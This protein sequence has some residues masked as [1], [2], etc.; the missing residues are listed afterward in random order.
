MD[1]KVIFPCNMHSKPENCHHIRDAAKNAA[2]DAVKKV[3]EILGVDVSVPKEVE[4]FRGNLR[5]GAS[6]RR[7][8]DKG[9]LAIIGAVAIAA[10]AALWA[11]TISMITRGN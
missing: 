11:G 6:L 8:A 2:D 5:F 7:A 3:F 4:D 9:M 10:I 1:E